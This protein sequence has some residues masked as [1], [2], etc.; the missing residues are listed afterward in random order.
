MTQ[1]R[2]IAPLLV[3]A[4]LAAIAVFTVASAGCD[5]PGRYELVA[6]GYQLIG[7]CLAPGDIVVPH[8]TP[9]EADVTNPSA[10]SKE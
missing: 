2:A 8:P 3:A 9:Q 5:D 4:V 10:P 6:G 7:G 1:V